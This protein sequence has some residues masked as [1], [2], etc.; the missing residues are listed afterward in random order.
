MA[1]VEKSIS[2]IFF[3]I[4]SFYVDKKADVNFFRQKPSIC[5]ENL[6]VGFRGRS[7]KMALNIL[8]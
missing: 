7:L 4:D 1:R 8:T 5:E 3:S 6:S 2:A